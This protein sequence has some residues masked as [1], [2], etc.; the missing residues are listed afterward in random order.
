MTTSPT[1]VASP[2]PL[3]FLPGA[4]RHGQQ[5][6]WPC[7]IGTQTHWARLSRTITTFALLSVLQVGDNRLFPSF[8]PFSFRYVT[9]MVFLNFRGID[10]VSN[11]KAWTDYEDVFW[12]ITPHR[13][14]YFIVVSEES[15]ASIFRVEQFHSRNTWKHCEI[16]ESF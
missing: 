15:V 12:D 1:N 2:H 13:L 10:A 16:C 14:V 3:P 11:K 5:T 9:G 8:L 6:A 4:A 7:W